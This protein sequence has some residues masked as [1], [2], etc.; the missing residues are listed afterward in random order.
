MLACIRPQ[1]R[2]VRSIRPS[3]SGIG[4]WKARDQDI[5]SPYQSW[6]MFTICE[7]FA[8]ARQ[9]SALERPLTSVSSERRGAAVP[10]STNTPSA[11]PWGARRSPAPFSTATKADILRAAGLVG[12][13]CYAPSHLSRQKSR[14]THRPCGRRRSPVD[15]RLGLRGN[16]NR[17][18]V[19]LRWGSRGAVAPIGAPPTIG[20]FA[21]H[22][23]A[24]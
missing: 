5:Q 16:R 1:P 10:I 4:T 12:G 8:R 20:H 21:H 15:H 14:W 22:V 23:V 24:S 9:A 6:L 2:K 7:A 3:G 18:C 19:G 17:P 11:S 13:R